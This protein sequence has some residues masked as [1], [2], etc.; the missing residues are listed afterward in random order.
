VRRHC[1]AVAEQLD[2]YVLWRDGNG[3][4]SPLED[5]AEELADRLAL[6]NPRRPLSREERRRRL[7]EW[8]DNAIEIGE[9][10]GSHEHLDG[11][12]CPFGVPPPS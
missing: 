8:G 5:P 11:V 1:R 4:G 3:S 12:E 10:V 2:I 7:V 6:H 9:R